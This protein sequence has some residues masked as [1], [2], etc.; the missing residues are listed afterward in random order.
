MV[1][2]VLLVDADGVTIKRKG[3]GS[4]VALES[5]HLDPTGLEEFFRGVFL[6]CER[7]IVDT[8]IAIQPFLDKLGWKKDVDT[9]LHMWHEYEN[10]VNSDL[11]A[12]IQEFRNQG[13]Y[14]CLSTDNDPYRM[15]YIKEEMKFKNYFDEIF[16]SSDIGFLKREEAFWQDVFDRLQDRF[17]D[18]KKDE[19]EVWD[20]DVE[21]ITI[22]KNFGFKTKIIYT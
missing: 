8:K 22:A 19:V 5:E 7:G 2:T 1:K 12:N 4:V 21:N 11:V 6:D 16:C 18:L 13:V 17:P 10:N 20:D 15:Q 3:Y 14:C 9:F